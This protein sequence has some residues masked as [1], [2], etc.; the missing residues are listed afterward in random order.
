[1]SV[2]QA[3]YVCVSDCLCVCVCVHGVFSVCE[4]SR[5]WPVFLAVDYDVLSII[6]GQ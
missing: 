1:M 6:L 4:N 2:K 5:Q 3:M